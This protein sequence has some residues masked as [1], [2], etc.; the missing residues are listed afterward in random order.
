MRRDVQPVIVVSP[1]AWLL[2]KFWKPIAVA[3]VLLSVL[4]ALAW[5]AIHSMAAD[6]AKRE[7]AIP[8]TY[9][10]ETWRV[11]LTQAALTPTLTPP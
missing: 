3:M 2:I 11:S 4:I 10:P 9:I 7:S 5:P 8:T 6:V 1:W